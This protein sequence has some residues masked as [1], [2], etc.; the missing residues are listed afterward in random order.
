MVNERRVVGRW[1]VAGLLIVHAVL[2]AW[3]GYQHSPTIDEPAH[4]AAGISH[5]QFGRMDLYSVNPPLV[6]MVA[7]IPVLFA[8]PELRWGE[9]R[10]A[11]EMRAEFKVGDDFADANGERI[12]WLTTIARWACIPFSLLGGWYCCRWAGELF[13]EPSGIMALVLWCFSPTI[14]GNGSLITAD[15]PAASVSVMSAY[16]FWHWLRERK[17]RQSYLLGCLL[18]LGL[19]TKSSLMLWGVVFPV[20]WVLDCFLTPR[21]GKTPN[22]RWTVELAQLATQWTIALSVLNLGYGFEGTLTPLGRYQFV[23]HALTGVEASDRGTVP[24]NRFRDSWLGSVPVP[25]PKNFLIGID[26]QKLDFETGLRSYFRGEIKTDGEGWWWF[27]LYAMLT[28][29]PLGTLLLVGLALCCGR[30]N[31]RNQLMLLAPMFAVLALVSSQQ[32]LNFFRYLLPAFPFL[33]VWISQLAITFSGPRLLLPASVV[34][35]TCWS[36]FS[37][38]IIYPHSLS[39]FNESIGSAHAFR[40]MADSN[41]DWGQDLKLLQE[42]IEDNAGS[43]SVRLDYYG[44]VRPHLAGIDVIPDEDS[45]DTPVW[46]AFSVTKLALQ[47]GLRGRQNQPAGTADNSL[48]EYFFQRP[49]DVR[50]GYSIHV[51][52]VA[53]SSPGE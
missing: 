25:L 15:V 40:V 6:R 17:W 21:A 48:L 22:R 13:G 38:L 18:G 37:S 47:H 23:S 50:I 10:P 28:K 2:L 51:Y 33:F 35:L 1:I 53:S 11:D 43:G 8:S 29:V 41:L 31:G 44:P 52:R 24:G 16:Y 9:F 4:L 30:T 7:A 20:V 12:F 5:W 46:E 34:L 14:L 49:P 19:L 42:W 39:Y 45:T 36:V 3:S 27:Y 26:W 32:G